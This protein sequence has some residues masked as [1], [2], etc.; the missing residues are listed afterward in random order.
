MSK[1]IFTP[2]DNGLDQSGLRAAVLRPGR[3]WSALDVV[4]QTGST[5]ADLLAAARAGAAHGTVL[6]A[7][8][9]TSGRG[10]RGRTW[11]TPPAASA[12]TF[13]VLLRP[14]GIPPAGRGWLPLLA[15]VAVAR[16]LRAAA[17]VDAV[18]KWPN[19]V[20]AGE[21]KLAGILAEQE[22]DAIV[23]GIGI[24]VGA[25][26]EDLPPPRPD[27]LPPTSLALLGAA[28]TDRTALLTA[29]LGELADWYQRWTTAGDATASGLR[30]EYLRNCAT[31][32]TAVRVELPG[33]AQL[34][35]T[36]AGIG[37][38]GQLLVD[39]GEGLV[40]VS[41]GDVIHLR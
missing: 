38:T 27:A 37:P 32:G 2:S 16:A 22:G 31:I 21:A 29:V 10:R 40:P 6:A 3:I 30:A 8:Q 7:E 9:Q 12:L 26:R 36:A 17:A 13:S 14:V 24:N 41:A 23:V 39:A 5:N 28:S 20:L 25:R 34:A 15:G 4:A 19:D 1:P 35:G 18:L 33:G 11:E